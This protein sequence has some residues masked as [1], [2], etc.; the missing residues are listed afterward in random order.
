MFGRPIYFAAGLSF[1]PQELTDENRPSRRPSILYQQWGP[2]LC[3]QN[4]HRHS[5]HTAPLFT[6]GTMSQIFA[7][8]STPIVF[9]LP[10][11][12]TV[13]L[14]RKLIQTCQGPIIGLS[15]YQ[16]RGRSIPPTLR[17]VG[18]LG[19][20]KDKVEIF[21]YILHSSGPCHLLAP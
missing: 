17:S 9:R 13:A 21:L 4:I 8:I 12:G 20:L 16:T 14:Y 10:Y 11:F 15:P 1:L 2:R 3:S 18:A 19:T 6:G 5:T 7:Q